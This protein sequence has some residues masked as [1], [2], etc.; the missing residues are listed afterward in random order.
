MSSLQSL[1]AAA[2][3]LSARP[4]S[5]ISLLEIIEDPVADVE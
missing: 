3:G 2:P 5:I 4:D 1:V